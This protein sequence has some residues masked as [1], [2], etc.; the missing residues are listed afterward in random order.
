MARVFVQS[1]SYDSSLSPL[2]PRS[3]QPSACPHRC[4]LG[5]RPRLIAEAGTADES[6]KQDTSGVGQRAG[7]DERYPRLS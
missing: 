2:G 4:L 3:Y 1:A 6:M 7:S 5:P